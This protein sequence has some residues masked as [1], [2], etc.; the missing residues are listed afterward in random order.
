[1]QLVTAQMK[2]HGSRARDFFLFDSN[3]FGIKKLDYG[4]TTAGPTS[5]QV[6]NVLNLIDAA[7]LS[8][9]S[10]AI[11]ALKH[12]IHCIVLVPAN[13]MLDEIKLI[14]PGEVPQKFTNRAEWLPPIF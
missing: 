8:K 3:I 6:S 14:R 12:S 9:K 7:V 4:T 11:G 1:M 10:R 2:L 5:E 13:V